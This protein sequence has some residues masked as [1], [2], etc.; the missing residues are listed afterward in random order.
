MIPLPANNTFSS[1]QRGPTLSSSNKE[2]FLLPPSLSLS[3]TRTEAMSHSPSG[4]D[5]PG[6]MG[7]PPG[8]ARYGSAPGSFLGGIA[9]S[10]I[11]AGGSERMMTRFYASDSPCLTSESSCR[12]PDGDAAAAAA[13][14]AASAAGGCSRGSYG[15]GELHLSSTT[16]SPLVRHSSLPSGFFS[17][18]LPDHGEQASSL[19]ILFW[20]TMGY[21]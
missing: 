13:V 7:P 6:A 3:T 8:L 9:D 10:V 19:L 12:G 4:G 11:A 21:G 5:R 20:S 15:S 18:L 16:G 2:A 1:S 14:A 17:H